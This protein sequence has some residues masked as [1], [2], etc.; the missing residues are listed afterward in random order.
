LVTDEEGGSPEGS[1]HGGMAR[2]VGNDSDGQCPVVE[3]GGS[4]FGK[5]VGTRAVVGVASTER[6]GG[7]RWLG[8][9]RRLEQRRTTR[10]R[11]ERMRRERWSGDGSEEV[12]KS[13]F[14]SGPIRVGDK[15]AGRRTWPTAVEL[16]PP[17]RG[18]AAGT[19]A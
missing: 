15:D 19:H 17:L 4:W 7:Q 14:A 13:G 11:V 6:V 18:Q 5:V 2:P 10:G 16:G 9:G 3:V 12:K 1:V 8:D